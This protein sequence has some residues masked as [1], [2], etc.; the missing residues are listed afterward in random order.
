MLRFWQLRRKEATVSTV[1]PTA[2]ATTAPAAPAM[3]QG[4]DEAPLP[5]RIKA[6]WATGAFGVAILMNGISALAMFY[7]VSVL[8]VPPATAGFLLFLSKL[9]DAV[10]D[11]LTG[12]LSD[13]TD[14]NAG[15][16]R[17]WLF[18][19]AIVSAVSFVAVFTVPFEGPGFAT[20]AY[21]LVALI[22]Y[23]SGY[24]MFNVPYMAMPAEMTH[25]YHERSAIHGW[26]VMFASVGGFLSQSMAGFVL[27]VMGKDWDAHAA[28][29]ALGGALILASMLT[30]WAGTKG[31]PSY[32][33]T[34]K[35]LP[36]REQL[37]GFLRNVPF[38]QILA[39][40]L[41]QLIGVSASSGGLMFFLVK[42][43]DM[44][45]TKLPL[46]G[47]PM[48]L[49][50]LTCT[51]LLV[52]LS[53]QIGKR[54]AYVLSALLTGLVGM[55]WV[56]AVP[57]EPDLLLVV[58]GFFNGIAFAGNVVFAMS[59]LTDAMELD[60]HRTGQR[61]EGMYSALYSF[62]EKLAAAVG[63]LVLGLALAGAG[64]DP[65]TPPSEVTEE[66][67]Q[68]VLL[69]IAYIPAAMALLA[70]FILSFYRLDEDALRKLR[71]STER[72]P[73]T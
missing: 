53:K 69:S 42:V 52:K 17:P 11:P 16:R 23:T 39:I 44:P 46:I 40:K 70:I 21:I 1:N 15:R 54:T 10:S 50:V 4:S 66:V 31:A 32:P 36:I 67:R 68:A 60:Y 28:V 27:E 13:R 33:R 34:D 51:P 12:W 48:V 7:F 73:S 35:P 56:Y 71:E 62:V 55:S 2:P 61:R 64:F 59:M 14:S 41:V 5:V 6:M 49:A 72:S 25:G 38:Q 63:P 58:R 3:A 47:G 45:L 26:R 57:G 19:G 9:Y 43:V 29:G 24:S 20:S 18:W 8:G 37:L 30:A 22:V 65:K